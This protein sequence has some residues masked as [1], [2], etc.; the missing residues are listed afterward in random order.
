VITE[1]KEQKC[2]QRFPIPQFRQEIVNGRTGTN[3]AV[4]PFI[5]LVEE[6][7]ARDVRIATKGVHHPRIGRHSKGPADSEH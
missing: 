5:N 7:G 2:R 6:L 3:R 1:S 4:P